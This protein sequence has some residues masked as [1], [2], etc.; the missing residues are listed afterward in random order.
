MKVI[1]C[2]IL[3]FLSNTLV[4]QNLVL[5]PS[6]EEGAVCDGSTERIDK[7]NNWS[8]VAGNPSYINTSCFLSKE[9]KAFVQ[10]MKL[11]PASEGE[12]LSVQK[13]DRETEC[14]Q[15]ELTKPLEEGKKYIVQMR[16]RLPIQFCQQAINDVGVVLSTTALDTYEDRS[17]IDLPALSLKNNTQTPISKQYEWEEVSALYTAKGG[18]QFIAI[19]NFSSN[20]VGLFENRGK[21]E[22]TYLFIDLVSVS[23]FTEQVLVQ[24]VPDMALKKDQRLLLKEVVFE[25]GSD[26]LKPSSFK[27]LESLA[28]TLKGNSNIKVE[29]VSYTDNSLDPSES[30]TFSKARAKVL[31]Q[32]LEN[33]EVLSSQVE[34]I[35]RG[36]ANAITLNSSKKERQKNER[37]EIRFIKL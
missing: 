28:K 30:L 13:F 24:Y 6:F 32:W 35:G 22:C 1:R 14:Q 26:V 20:N 15:G 34:S 21:K 27:I 36:S 9:S 31:T 4:G 8:N 16:V 25:E 37:T 18:E 2:L 5:N 19:G 12:V 7:I 33:K 17:V 29:I 11:P 10:G 23:E 3:V